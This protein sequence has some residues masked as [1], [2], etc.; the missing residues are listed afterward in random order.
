MDLSHLANTSTMNMVSTANITQPLPIPAPV[1]QALPTP[2]SVTHQI[3]VPQSQA[4]SLVLKPIAIIKDSNRIE[5]K[6]TVK[7]HVKIGKNIFAIIQ[8]G[9]TLKNISIIS[10]VNSNAI[11]PQITK[12]E[13]KQPV[14][15]RIKLEDHDYA[16]EEEDIDIIGTRGVSKVIISIYFS[17]WK[18]SHGS[19]KFSIL[20]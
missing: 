20:L 10:S 9:N 8:N 1:T 5:K 19:I 7:S 16:E 12:T 14:I 11:V 6:A 13:N 17:R 18:H 4:Q 2:A 3:K 15:H